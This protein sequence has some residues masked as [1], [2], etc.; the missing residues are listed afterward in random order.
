MGFK[1]HW[2]WLKY[3]RIDEMLLI[4]RGDGPSVL[5]NSDG[6]AA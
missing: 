6:K 5:G 2:N 1:L 3:I 4:D